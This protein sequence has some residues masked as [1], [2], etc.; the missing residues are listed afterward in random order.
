MVYR[1]WESS[2]VRKLNKNEWFGIGGNAYPE[3]VKG[4]GKYSVLLYTTNICKNHVYQVG[5]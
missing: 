5:K 1:V 3:L 2:F 4:I